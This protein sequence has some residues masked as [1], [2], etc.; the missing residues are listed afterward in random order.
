MLDSSQPCR[1]FK[2]I[3]HKQPPL[4]GKASLRPDSC[5]VGQPPCLHTAKHSAGCTSGTSPHVK[6][7]MAGYYIVPLPQTTKACTTPHWANTHC[8]TLL[9][10][11][12]C[13]VHCSRVV[14]AAITCSPTFTT[15]PLSRSQ[16]AVL[17]GMLFLGYAMAYTLHTH[18]NQHT[19]SVCGHS[20]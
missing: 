10:N 8:S 15:G 13:A 12:V 9:N 11:R 5:R 16:R 2:H 17:G 14:V 18:P 19:H 7:L 3:R 6:S 20:L 4:Y 1:T